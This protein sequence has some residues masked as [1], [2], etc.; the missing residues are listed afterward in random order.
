M[1]AE[2]KKGVKDRPRLF[3]I[4]SYG[5]IFQTLAGIGVPMAR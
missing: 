4:D 5:F 2:G 1:E 3:P